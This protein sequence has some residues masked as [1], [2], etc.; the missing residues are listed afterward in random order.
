MNRLNYIFLFLIS[1]CSS[2]LAQEEPGSI[3][4]RVTDKMTKEGLPSVNITVKG[5]Y[6]GASSDI[7]GNFVI[8]K[9]NPGTYVIEVKLLGYKAVQFGAVKV[10]AGKEI[11]LDAFMEET[12]LS[13]GQEVVVVGEKPMFDIEET[14]SKRSLQAEDLRAAAV[15]NVQDVMALQVGV[16]KSDDQIHIRGGR[17]YETAFMVDG[18]SVQDPLSGTGFGLSLPPGAVQEVEVITGGYNAEYGQATSGVVNFTTREGAEKYSGSLVHKQ[19]HLGFNNDDRS[20]AKT[21]IYEFSLGGP[22][23]ITSYVLPGLGV[24]VPG[25][26][27]FFTNVNVNLSDTYTRWVEKTNTLGQP[28]GYELKVP[29]G[30]YS[31]IFHGS[32]FAPRRSNNWSSLSKLT[33]KI[34]PT[35]KL[36]Y[37]FTGSVS[38]NQNTQTI[39]TTL[40]HQ[41]PQPGYQYLFQSIPDSANTFTQINTQHAL[42]WTHTI[43]PKTY[44]EIRLSRYFAHVRGDANGRNWDHYTEPKDIVTYPVIYYNLGHD[45]VGVIPGDG[46]YDVGSPTVWRD[47]SISENALKFDITS[48]FDE[49]NKFKA[50]FENRFQH[51]Q[52]IDITSPWVRPMGFNNDIYA[53]DAIQGAFYAQDN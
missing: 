2:V 28:E 33:W 46:F 32:Q 23:P 22:E 21:D 3:K 15:Q 19:D 48:H 42:I 37:S 53:V 20:N 34:T 30:L 47:H 24:E 4:G 25:K 7:D 13:L 18:I 26:M 17:S 35:T 29:G 43:S 31:S 1:T 14:S 45:T 51:M 6:Y 38:I 39:Q 40:E 8:P 9:V 5:T 11:R 50:G 10:E 52:M 44:Y 16:V 12:S 49:K 27:S 36:A 41:E